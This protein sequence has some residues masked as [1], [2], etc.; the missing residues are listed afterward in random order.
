MNLLQMKLGMKD[1][2]RGRRKVI[3]RKE[4]F[5]GDVNIQMRESIMPVKSKWRKL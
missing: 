5:G 4:L 1:E 2:S 3:R